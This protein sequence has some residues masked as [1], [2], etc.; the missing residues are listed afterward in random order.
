MKRFS[1]KIR[2]FSLALAFLMPVAI[3]SALLAEEVPEVLIAERKE[4]LSLKDIERL[5]EEVE[6]AEEAGNFQKVIKILEQILAI[7]TKEL[8]PEHPDIANSLHQLAG[9]YYRQGLYI[10]AE[11]LLLQSLVIRK[12]S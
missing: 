11:P 1:D 8:G 10:K 3:E 2:P 6:E 9:S 4:K 7:E 12:K 5:T